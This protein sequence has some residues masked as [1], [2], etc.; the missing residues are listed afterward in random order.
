M[1]KSF[2]LTNKTALVTGA[3]QGLGKTFALALAN[4]GAE[5]YILARNIDRLTN[6]ADEDYAK[7]SL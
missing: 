1:A 5:V 7:D 6:T 3:G 4:A 2:D